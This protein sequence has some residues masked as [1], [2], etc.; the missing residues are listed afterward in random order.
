MT[1]QSKKNEATLNI[2][3]LLIL[4]AIVI[5]GATSRV[6][7]A[8]MPNFKPVAALALFAGFYFSSFRFAV[9]AALLMMLASDLWLGIYHWQIAACVYGSIVF[10]CGLGWLI[11][12]SN[13]HNARGWKA[14][15][16]GR[17][18]AASLIMSTLFYGL[19]NFGVWYTGL[20]YETSMT[21][22]ME[23]F[24]AGIPFFRSTITG[25]LFFTGI[26]VGGYWACCQIWQPRVSA[27]PIAK[28][29]ARQ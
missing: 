23:C 14:V 4:I 20:W 13:D 24:V 21:G 10:C 16:F 3:T 18:G 1:N 6:W 8:E 22:L 5:V 7:M 2:F 12:K 27:K 15:D 28:R 25:D 17:F 11:S 29:S 19:T 26:L 9:V